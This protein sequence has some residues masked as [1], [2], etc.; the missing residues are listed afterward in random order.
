MNWSFTNP[1]LATK[2]HF[3]TSTWQGGEIKIKMFLMSNVLI[4]LIR[5]KTNERTGKAT[6]I[7]HNRTIKMTYSTIDEK[8]AG[9]KTNMTG[10]TN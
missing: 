9:K 7:N 2:M 4:S 5:N 6:M 3:T 10:T 1:G 8:Q